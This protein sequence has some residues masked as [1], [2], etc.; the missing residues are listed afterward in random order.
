M[1][2]LL[3]LLIVSLLTSE[4]LIAQEANTEK[5]DQPIKKIQKNTNQQTL[6]DFYGTNDAKAQLILKKYSKEIIALKQILVNESPML[7]TN[8]DMKKY[9]QAS[10]DLNKLE[11]KIK[12]EFGFNFITI[13]HV[14]YPKNNNIYITVNTI[15][16]NQ[17]EKLKYVSEALNTEPANPNTT[18]AANN[19]SDAVEEMIKFEALAL[20]YIFSKKTFSRKDL[21]CPVYH[22]IS[23]FADPTLKPYLKIFNDA[24]QNHLDEIVYILN[25]DKNPERR[26]AAVFIIGHLKNPNKIIEILLPQI[27]SENATVRNNTMRTISSTM[28]KAKIYDVNPLPFIQLL[29]S[30]LVTD[31]NKSL[32]VLKQISKSDKHKYEIIKYGKDRLI[33]NLR[34]T[35]PNNHNESYTI[36]KEVSGKN[37]S[38]LDV[39]GWEKW[40]TKASQSKTNIKT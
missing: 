36:L 28:S 38:D 6:I 30:P 19:K 17:P 14:Q 31:R 15:E 21:I 20:K 22:C 26:A 29:D 2:K 16:P 1:N 27:N 25:N 12:N 5:T 24:A 23:G 9:E 39:K 35:Q 8:P 40:L 10:Y 34:L 18:T 4:T 3:P 37:Y 13:E 11:N 32:L 33:A 7:A